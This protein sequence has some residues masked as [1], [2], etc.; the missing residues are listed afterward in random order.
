M[1]VVWCNYDKIELLNSHHERI[2][3]PPPWM[4]A[5][6][7]LSHPS[8]DGP[9]RDARRETPKRNMLNHAGRRT[10]WGGFYLF[11]GITPTALFPTTIAG[12]VACQKGVGV[13][14]CN[15]FN[16]RQRMNSSKIDVTKVECSKSLIGIDWKEKTSLT[17]QHEHLSKRHRENIRHFH[18]P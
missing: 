3:S 9:A 8:K 10:N 18:L 5:D 14:W 11:C 16:T 2:L 6:M 17:D 12:K 7:P 13:G 1:L 15:F 4:A